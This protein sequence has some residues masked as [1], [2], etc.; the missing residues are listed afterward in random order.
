VIKEA[1]HLEI[2]IF[3]KLALLGL[4]PLALL[5]STPEEVSDTFVVGLGSTRSLSDP[6]NC[7]GV[8]KSDVPLKNLLGLVISARLIANINVR[9]AVANSASKERLRQS[10]SDEKMARPRNWAASSAT[11]LFILNESPLFH[12]FFTQVSAR[13]SSKSAAHSLM[14]L[15]QELTLDFDHAPLT[16]A[17]PRSNKPVFPGSRSDKETLA[18]AGDWSSQIWHS[19]LGKMGQSSIDRLLP[20]ERIDQA[21]AQFINGVRAEHAVLMGSSEMVNKHG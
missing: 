12:T 15:G 6:M 8:I 19:H 1:V 3:V 7:G 18:V 2:D 16:E 17:E 9:L 20:S 14:P 10:L 11:Y 4:S 5:P 21:D 13:F